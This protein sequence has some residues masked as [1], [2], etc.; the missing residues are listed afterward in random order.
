MKVSIIVTAHNNGEELERNLP[1]FFEQDY[2]DDYEVIVVVEKGEDDTDDALKRLKSN[3]SQL[4]S[5]YVP[6]SSR[7]ISRKK[8]AVTLGVKAAKNEWIILTEATCRPLSN[9]WISA[10][11]APT[12]EAADTSET[13]DSQ[14]DMVLGYANFDEETSS[15]KRFLCLQRQ[16]S[17][18]GRSRRWTAYSQE[19]RNL[20][21]RKS[22]FL[23]GKGYNG[24]LKYIGGEYEFL[25]NKFAKRGNTAI[26]T[27]PDAW[28]E[29]ENPTAKQWKNR[30]LF[31][32]ET[33]RHLRRSFLHRL[34]VACWQALVHLPY[35]AIIA[36]LV[37]SIIHSYWLAVGFATVALIGVYGVRAYFAN[38][39]NVAFD[40]KI[41]V[42][43]L[44][45]YEVF[46]AWH[47]LY[48]IIRYRVADKN[49]FI[50]HKI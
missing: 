50:C 5:T 22:M 40:A 43:K 7:Y 1:H 9:H 12:R 36:L 11:T 48:N 39:S 26:A 42:W 25:V 29:E 37:W 33:R 19:C 17:L 27:A 3:Y 15:F 44:P 46:W 10:M 34:Q 8:L 31:H 6:T 30:Q 47:Y 23:E 13:A 28:L 20:M 49:S 41:P 16:Q 35:I 38:W 32:L 4:Y 45:F 18:F 2:D 14:Y 21:F 24:N